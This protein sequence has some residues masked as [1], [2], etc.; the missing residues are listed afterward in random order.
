MKKMSKS[1]VLA[2]VGALFLTVTAYA[3]SR[4]FNVTEG[5]GNR[6]QFTSDAPLERM[7]GTSTAVSGSFTL[8]PANVS[9]ARGSL[10]VRIASLRTG[11]D[12]RDE[13]LRSETWLNAAAYPTARFEITSVSGASTLTPGTEARVS[14]HGN[15]TLH[16]RTRPVTASAR[17]T[18]VADDQGHGT[19]QV[20]V[21]AHFSVHLADYGVSIPEVVQLKV[22]ET[23]GVDVSFRGNAG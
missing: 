9:A 21:R 11:I 8:D 20:R 15:F 4:T 23:I 2:I 19:G 16:G 5:G 1:S 18:W 12:L 13:H 14:L 17:V 3:Q 6:V 10:S 22:S 7:V